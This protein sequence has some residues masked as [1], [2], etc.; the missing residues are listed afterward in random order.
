MPPKHRIA[1]PAGHRQSV[2]RSL[3]SALFTHEAIST[4]LPRAKAAQIEAEKAITVVKKSYA[5]LRG[6]EVQAAEA[7]LNR[8]WKDANVY[9]SG[10]DRVRKYLTVSH[11]R[12]LER[13]SD[14]SQANGARTDLIRLVNV[15]A[16]RFADRPGGYTRVHKLGHRKGDHAPRAILELVDGPHDLKFFLAAMTVGRQLAAEYHRDPWLEDGLPNFSLLEVD[17]AIPPPQLEH[18]DEPPPPMSPMQVQTAG[19]PAAELA[20]GELAVASARWPVLGPAIRRKLD[21][22]TLDAVDKACQYRT[23]HS[24]LFFEATAHYHFLREKARDGKDLESEKEVDAHFELR[25]GPLGQGRRWSEYDLP[26]SSSRV[27]L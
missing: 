27:S 23:P 16:P 20:P 22:R 7:G 15:I 10:A 17:D 21:E 6:R 1:L 2:L 3:V 5:R 18:A 9:S 25:S 8:P 19:R 13:L 24:L 26:P 4:T 12:V 11:Q 14:I